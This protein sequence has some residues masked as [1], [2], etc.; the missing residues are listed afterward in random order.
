MYFIW[1][2]CLLR[3]PQFSSVFASWA[4]NIKIVEESYR[5][6]HIQDLSVPLR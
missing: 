5:T 1:L 4:Y 6:L 3:L 2:L